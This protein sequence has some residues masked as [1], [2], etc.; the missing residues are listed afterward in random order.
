MWDNQAND[1]FCLIIPHNVCECDTV[2][3]GYVMIIIIIIT[4]HLY[5]AIYIPQGTSQKS[6]SIPYT[7][8]IIYFWLHTIRISMY[9]YSILYKVTELVKSSLKP[10]SRFVLHYMRSNSYIWDMSESHVRFNGCL[11]PWYDK[12]Y[13]P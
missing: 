11:W 1:S 12:S 2:C 7:A 10:Y 9:W 3:I 5:S 13:D 4:L 8:V 6:L